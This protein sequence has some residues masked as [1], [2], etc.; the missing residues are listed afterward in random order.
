[1]KLRF[2]VTLLVMIIG[3][4][5]TPTAWSLKP[6]VL[7]SPAADV[8]WKTGAKCTIKWTGRR[9]GKFVKIRLF[10][11]G[12]FD[13]LIT[14]ST[15]NDGARKWTIPSDVSVAGKNVYTIRI[16]GVVNKNASDKSGKFSFRSTW[17][18]TR[19]ESGC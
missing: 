5:A 19:A 14:A 6:L 10:K 7:V 12:K 2:T 16:S 13:Q 11:L 17:G 3:L 4:T 8:Q 15:R 9:G 1:M 18:G